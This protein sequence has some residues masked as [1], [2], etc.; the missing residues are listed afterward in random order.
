MSTNWGAAQYGLAN[1]TLGSGVQDRGVQKFYYHGSTY[2]PDAIWEPNNLPTVTAPVDFTIPW[3]D[4][5][6][7]YY[8]TTTANPERPRFIPLVK[9]GQFV[10]LRVKARGWITA[11]LSPVQDGFGGFTMSVRPSGLVNGLGSAAN[12]GRVWLPSLVLGASTSLSGRYVIPFSYEHTY[13]FTMQFPLV[14]TTGITRSAEL[15]LA[16]ETQKINSSFGMSCQF[17]SFSPTTVDDKLYFQHLET[18]ISIL[19]NFSEYSV[20]NVVE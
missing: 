9:K 12:E 14:E 8:F 17:G 19:Q 10:K 1:D 11:G 2:S 3:F 4:A 13:F 20:S 6:S 7:P 16:N 15:H 5:K 18:E